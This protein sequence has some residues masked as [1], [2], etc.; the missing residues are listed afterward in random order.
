MD[1]NAIT[2]EVYYPFVHFDTIEEENESMTNFF[3][4][5]PW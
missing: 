5:K 3:E 2:Y 1:G 4:Y